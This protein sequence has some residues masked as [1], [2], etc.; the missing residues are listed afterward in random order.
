MRNL[1]IALLLAATSSAALAQPATRPAQPPKLLIAI[2]VD[3]LS[4]DIFDEYRPHFTAGLKRLSGGTVF[5]N[6][7]QSHAATETCPGHST[8]LTAKRPASNGI[9][10][11]SWIDQSASRQDQ[12]IYCAEDESVAGST[13]TSYSVSPIHLN[14]ETLGDRF[15]KLSPASRNVA[16]AGKDRAAVMMGGRNVDQRWYWNGQIFATDLKAR[17]TPAVVTAFN[18]GLTTAL[19]VARP[20]LAPPPLCSARARGY[21]LAPGVRAGDHRFERAAGD[22]RAFR[23]SPEFDGATLALSAGLIQEMGLGRGP[24][25][26]IISVGLSATD[27]IGHAYGSGGME[28]CLQ[29][30]A[31]DRELGDFFAQLDLSGI[32]Y[33]VMLTADHGVMDLPERLRDKGVAD[34]A[35]ADPALAASEVGKRLA[36][37]VN[38]TDSVLKGIGIAGDIWIDASLPAAERSRVLADALASYRAH[39]Q[40]FA[41]FGRD[42]IMKVAMPTGSPDRWSVIERIRAS[43]DPKRSGDLY[44]VLKQHISPIAVPSKGYTATHGSVWDHDRRVPILFWRKGMAASDRPEHIETVDIM[45]TLAALLGLAVDARA[46]DGKCLGDVEGISCP[47]R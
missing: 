8:M 16:V 9:V 10:A 18:V 19:A 13:S 39:P 14:A 38:R 35:R 25:T 23:I 24:A 36:P 17:P 34:A 30:L 42:E 1:G 11:N 6:G 12:V 47:A 15:K 31:L 28:M 21:D 5:R 33:A 32:D 26:D 3:Q 27:Y 29:V 43:F 40:V 45:P 20:A 37:R 22:L 46:L 4:G 44:V 2:S 41:A 7:Y